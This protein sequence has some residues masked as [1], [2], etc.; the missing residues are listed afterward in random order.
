MK[1]SDVKKYISSALKYN[2]CDYDSILNFLEKDNRKTVQ[3]LSE[4]V[5]KSIINREKEINRVK[6]LYNFDRKFLENGYIVG[7]DE[8][9]RGPLA[10]PIV[11]AAVVL[12]LNYESDSDLILHINDSKKLSLKLR[13][14]LDKI[15]KEK[16]ISYSIV[17]IDN[18]EIDN[19]GIAWSNNEVLKRAYE[20]VKIKPNLILSDGYAIKNCAYPN[21]FVVK[22]DA[23][24][25]SIA[26][27]SII[28]KVYRDN[29]MKK[30][31]DTY[32]KYEFDKNVGYGTQNHIKAIKKYGP[33]HIHRKSFLKNIL[34]M[35]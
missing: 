15:I 21:E 32:S 1:S 14:E 18:N 5:R 33:T 11:A 6:N 2:D 3:K 24:S 17:Q 34:N 10:G 9:G 22:G 26:C 35:F 4:N 16:A 12:D 20:G 27:A 28:A 30:Y 23:K 13:E 31:A 25:A 29:L 7:V 19:K 8:V